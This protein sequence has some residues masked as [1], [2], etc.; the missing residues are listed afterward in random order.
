MSV[1]GSYFDLIPTQC[2][3]PG[4]PC[5]LPAGFAAPGGAPL[6]R[7]VHHLVQ[8]WAGS[9]VGWRNNIGSSGWGVVDAIP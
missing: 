6:Q 3:N 7:P 2:V 1:F 4:A 9:G 8:V 5:I